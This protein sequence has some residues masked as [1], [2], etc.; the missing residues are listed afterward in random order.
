[1]MKDDLVHGLTSARVPASQEGG[2]AAFTSN[3]LLSQT[4]PFLLTFNEVGENDHNQIAVSERSKKIHQE[5]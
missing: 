1:M 4:S 3:K 2:V 5:N